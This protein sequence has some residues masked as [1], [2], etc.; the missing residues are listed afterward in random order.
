MATDTQTKNLVQRKLITKRG[1]Y[2]IL[3]AQ[4]EAERASFTA[5]W[6]DLGDYIFPRRPRF[7]ITDSN[8]GD[9]RN[10]KIVDSTG[11]MAART[12]R[13]GMMGGV[14]SPARRWFR[15]SIPDP[16]LSEI[17]EVK[18]WLD[19]VTARM[20][21][22]FL[23]SNLYNAL[24][25]VYGDMGVFGTGAL[26][27]E[28]DFEETMR[29]YPFPVG[30]YMVANDAKLRVKVFYR[31]FR[32][33][34]D[35]LLE[36]FGRRLKDGGWDWTNF[37]TNV[38]TL[39]LNNQGQQWVEIAHIIAPNPDWDE[40]KLH[41]KFKRYSSCYYERGRSQNSGNGSYIDQNAEDVFLRESGYDFFPVLVPRWETNA[42]DVYGTSCPGMEALGDIKALQLM[43]KR[44]AQALEKMVNPPMTGPASLRSQ[45]TSILPGDVTYVDIR[46]GQQGFRPAHEVDP[47]L[48]KLMLV[49]EAHQRRIQ[50]CFYEDLFRMLID[51][52]RN[53]PPTAE[54]V[55]ERNS[56]KLLALGPVLEQLN[57]DL[58]DPLIDLAF[59][60]MMRQGLVPEPPQQ[61]QGMALRVE[62]VSVMAQAQKLVGIASIERFAGF[63]LNII[64]QSQDPSHLD[65]IDIDQMLDVYADIVSLPQHIVRSDDDVDAIRSGRAQAQRAKAAQELMMNMG[66]TAKDLAGADTSGQN[67]LTDLLTQ[68]KAGE[69]VPTQ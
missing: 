29:F 36:R 45:R 30:S 15:L 20:E 65:K 43:H 35:Q 24:P 10:Q 61:L 18:D 62:Y 55:R 28:E 58:L 12:L 25:I 2:E 63:A 56:E 5:H 66:K 23:R 60:I 34:V 21:T 57:Q 33:T 6:R 26:M 50:R 27:V 1:G 48:D 47:R 32:M 53:Q 3:R 8:K 69:A 9:K 19:T 40:S 67:A 52:P 64:A 17:S 31:E 59:D 14:T 49:I 54:E 37:S 42:E 39:W 44:E 13:S 38:K 46:E 11:T 41:S 4:L 22:I 51:D 16:E 68:A 7:T